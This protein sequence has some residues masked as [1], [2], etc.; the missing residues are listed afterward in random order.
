M[1]I[2]GVLTRQKCA[3]TPYATFWTPS[4][5]D[6]VP[7]KVILFLGQLFP[8]FQLF[9]DFSKTVRCLVT[10]HIQSFSGPC[11]SEPHQKVSATEPIFMFTSHFFFEMT[12]PNTFQNLFFVEFWWPPKARDLS[13]AASGGF[14]FWKW[15]HFFYF[16]TKLQNPIFH[17]FSAF[18]DDF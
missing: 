10:S 8:Y 11:P 1:A 14:G 4:L 2:Q 16:A 6:L 3:E 18:F 12:L 9:R 5:D 13:P 17:D 7:Q 15:P